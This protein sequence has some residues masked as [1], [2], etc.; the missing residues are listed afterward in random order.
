[1]VLLAVPSDW[2]LV[3]LNQQT[4]QLVR[5]LLQVETFIRGSVVLALLL[6]MR[7]MQNTC[8]VHAALFNLND[9]T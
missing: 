8:Q 3:Q 5:R 1:M 9:E 4:L 2:V 6:L 7:L